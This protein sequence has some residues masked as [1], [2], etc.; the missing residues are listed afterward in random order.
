MIAAR[1]LEPEERK[2]Q[3]VAAAIDAFREKGVENTPVSDIVKRAGVGQGTFYLYF[4]TKDAIICAIVEAAL[5][6][7][8]KRIASAVDLPGATALEKLLVLRDAILEMNDEPHER[9]LMEF[10][11]RPENKAVHDR[12]TE[13]FGPRI[14]PILVRIIEQGVAEGVFDVNDPGL[15]AWFTIGG[16]LG[17]EMS[18]NDPEAIQLAF[19]DVTRMIVRGLGYDG[20]LD[21]N[22]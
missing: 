16:F 15:A 6:V 3:L 10:F 9:E 1:R 14:H 18:F 7:L 8:Y 20:E 4:K 21:Q 13:G 22:G 11:H 2:A 19:A 17:Y 12:V 5:K